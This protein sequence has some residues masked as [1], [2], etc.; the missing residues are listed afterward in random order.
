MSCVRMFSAGLCLAFLLL[1]QRALASCDAP[2]GWLPATPFP[3]YHAPPP[4]PA[5]DCPFY[6][7]AW[8]TFL[9][10]TQPDAAGQPAFAAYRRIED[11]FDAGEPRPAD[12]PRPALAADVDLTSG[13]W[14]AGV[15]GV[16]I[17]RNGAPV[18]YSM[19]FNDRF[20]D[21]VARNGLTSA[22]GIRRADPELAF[23]EAG[24]IELKSAWRVLDEGDDRSTYFWKEAWVPDL[25]EVGGEIGFDPAGGRHRATVGLVALHVVFTMEGHPEFVWS[26]FEHVGPDQQP[27]NAP[28]AAHNPDDTLDDFI[29]HGERSYPFYAA[30]SDADRCNLNGMPAPAALIA[31]FDPIAQRFTANGGL[32]TPVYREYPASKLVTAEADEALEEINRSVWQAFA[33]TDPAGADPRRHYAQVGATWLDRP[34]R[35][36]SVERAFVNAPGEDSDVG[37]VAGEDALSSIAMESFTQQ[38]FPG[39]FSC[40]D[41]REVYSTHG[42]RI[43]EPKKIN[44]SHAFSA[45]LSGVR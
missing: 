5:S 30:G 6:Q 33:A 13:V 14:Q 11:M 44:V 34:D 4:H 12:A 17:D 28:N 31:A 3:A 18:Y 26:T 24:I 45:F 8:Q 25:A 41:T 39:C 23:D 42:D 35:D 21:F 38:V 19:H 7:A 32:S 2:E 15:G 9:Y 36:F 1:G 40:H 22:A 43:M 27:D 20:A 10:V 37:P 29:A 16:L